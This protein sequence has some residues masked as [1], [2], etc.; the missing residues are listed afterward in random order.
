MKK[1]WLVLVLALSIMTGCGKNSVQQPTSV[2]IPVVTAAPTSA[3][4]LAVTAAPTPAETPAVTS[5]P[6]SAEPPAVTSAPTPAP[7]P[8]PTRVPRPTPT[9]APTPR[10]A[11]VRECAPIMNTKLYVLYREY[12]FDREEGV[13]HEKT[14][15]EDSP[16]TAADLLARMYMDDMMQPSDVRTFRIKEYKDLSVSLYPT[17]GMDELWV[18]IYDLEPWEISDDTWIVKIDVSYKYEG[19][20]SPIGSIDEWIYPLVEGSAVDF[21]LTRNRTEYT[22][23]SRYPAY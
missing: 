4:I 6:A 8:R 13:L 5:A 2:E 12:V 7:T 22:M 16:E 17:V 1:K 9:P 20:V 10:P 3:E 15:L 21:L 11:P 18:A 19:I 23:R 14:E